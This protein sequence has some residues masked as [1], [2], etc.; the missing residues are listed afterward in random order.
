VVK[1][2]TDLPGNS[3]EEVPYLNLHSRQEGTGSKR[4]RNEKTKSLRK[5]IR[6]LKD[7]LINLWGTGKFEKGD[8]NA[9]FRRGKNKTH[10]GDYSRS[11][12]Q[13]Q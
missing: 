12:Q 8:K 13:G 2:R 10:R 4:K 9:N 11:R 5:R 7:L 6:S 1:G 3:S